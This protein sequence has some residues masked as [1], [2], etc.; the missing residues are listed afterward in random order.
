[1][2]EVS[3]WLKK[4]ERNVHSSK[5]EV[6]FLGHRVSGDN[7]SVEVDKINKERYPME[8]VKSSIMRI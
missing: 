3:G 2:R 6:S 5:D 7:I 1:V 4:K 8:L